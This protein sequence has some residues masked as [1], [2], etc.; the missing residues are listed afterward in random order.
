MELWRPYLHKHCS[1]VERVQRRFTKRVIGLYNLS[2]G[3]RLRALKLPSLWWR[4]R[5]G[6]LITTF[7]ILKFDYGGTTIKNNFKLTQNLYTRGHP[8]KLDRSHLNHTKTQNFFF[9]RIIPIWNEL[10]TAVVSADS[11]NGFKNLL[12]HY[13]A[14]NGD[15]KYFYIE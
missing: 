7:K 15:L 6:A 11:V 4:F 3:D 8:W 9:N 5:R 12:D 14:T 1:A 13:I 2:Y 10:P